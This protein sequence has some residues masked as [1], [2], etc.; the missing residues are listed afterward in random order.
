MGDSYLSLRHVLGLLYTAP[1]RFTR[2]DATA[3]FWIRSEYKAE[4]YRDWASRQEPGSVIAL[5]PPDRGD[6]TS[7]RVI[8]DVEVKGPIC[9]RVSSPPDYEV[10]LPDTQGAP[11]SRKRYRGGSLI[12]PQA[13]LSYMLVHSIEETTVEGRPAIKLRAKPRRQIREVTSPSLRVEAD[14]YELIV[15]GERGVLLR[16]FAFHKGRA[17]AGEELQ[18]V[19]FHGP[20]AQ[21]GPGMDA[22]AEVVGLLYNARNSFSTVSASARDWFP[23]QEKRDTTRPDQPDETGATPTIETIE[24]ECRLW[25]ENPSRFR[26]EVT[27][28]GGAGNFA[29]HVFDGDTWWN[30]RPSGLVLTNAPR[31]QIQGGGAVTVCN[32]ALDPIHEDAEYAIIS[33]IALEP[34]WLISGLWMRPE[35]GT[36]HA[37][38]EAIR[39]LAKP[40]HIADIVWDWWEGADEYEL[41]VDAERGILLRIEARRHGEG[42]AGFE[43]TQIDFDL[44]I[45]SETF[46]YN[47][48]PG[49]TILVNP[50][51]Q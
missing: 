3:R 28:W 1:L 49:A 25:V 9:V 47:P 31:E 13:L 41:I 34:S 30:R 21:P 51:Q 2:L 16:L 6:S 35:N 42:F 23:P 32:E 7:R 11:S 24:S 45:P 5:P 10:F 22:I 26:E 4:A 36:R 37:G 48:P 8:D 43:V 38:R 12:C 33:Q 19:T 40:T 39:I 17:F 50:P 18:D 20:M 15:D 27:G 44:P 14:E 46:V 29:V